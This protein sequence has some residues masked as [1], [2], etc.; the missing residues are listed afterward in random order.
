M[1][2]YSSS[3]ISPPS[4]AFFKN[5]QS[6]VVPSPP[7]TLPKKAY[8]EVCHKKENKKTEEQATPSHHTTDTKRTKCKTLWVSEHRT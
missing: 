1:R 2:W 6:L 4:I 8:R 7:G 3:E 5:F